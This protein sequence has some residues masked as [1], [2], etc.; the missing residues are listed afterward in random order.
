MIIP[1]HD[2]ASL[3]PVLVSHDVVSLKPVQHVDS[4]KP[5]YT[6]VYAR[7]GRLQTSA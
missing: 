2:L 5:A 3:K 4:L 6:V 1:A 7:L